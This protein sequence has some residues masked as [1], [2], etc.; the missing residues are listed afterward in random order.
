MG[1][2]GLLVLARKHSPP[3]S[4]PGPASAAGALWWP[5]LQDGILELRIGA[6]PG[7]GWSTG[8]GAPAVLPAAS[9]QP[10]KLGCHC[11]GVVK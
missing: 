2:S 9:R 1:V 4:L 6:G 8:W 3:P 11:C 5:G 10:G 7:R